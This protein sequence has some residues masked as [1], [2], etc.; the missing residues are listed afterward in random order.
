MDG[1]LTCFRYREWHCFEHSCT[2]FCVAG[3]FCLRERIR[4]ELLG[5]IVTLG[6]TVGGTVR[7]FS[8]RLHRSL[9]PTMMDKGSRVQFA[10]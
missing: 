1:S 10:F 4:V 8:K 2:G 3:V 7:L 6:F 5:L 9:F